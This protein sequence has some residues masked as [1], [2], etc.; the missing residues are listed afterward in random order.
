MPKQ[1]VFRWKAFT[2]VTLAWSFILVS[3]SGIA[4][5]IAPSARVTKA[6]DWTFLFLEKGQ[7]WELHLTSMYVVVIAAIVHLATFNWKVFMTYIWKKVK[8]SV[9][10]PFET[11]AAVIFC[12]LLMA[13]T[14]QKWPVVYWAIDLTQTINEYHIEQYQKKVMNLR[15]VE[16]D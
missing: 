12:I 16:D 14:L 6:L 3:I 9:R 4:L 1:K 15:V 11:I 13:G 8:G 10:K 2:T 7:W 5:Y